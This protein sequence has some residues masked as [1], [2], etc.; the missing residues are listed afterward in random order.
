MLVKQVVLQMMGAASKFDKIRPGTKQ[1]KPTQP[2]LLRVSCARAN[3][4]PSGQIR[5]AAVALKIFDRFTN[6][7]DGLG[8]FV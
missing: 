3:L 4:I 7:G 1:V 8:I 6:R 5:L 2:T